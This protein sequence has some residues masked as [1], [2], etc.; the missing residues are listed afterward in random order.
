MRTYS[1]KKVQVLV[2]NQIITGF[3]EDTL[4]EIEKADD[5]FEKAIGA[6]GEVARTQ[7][8]DDSGTI[9]I[10]LMQ[11]SA[12]NDVLQNL[13]DID[14]LSGNDPFPV[15]V[16]DGSGRA[17]YSAQEAWIKKIPNSPFKKRA[18]S[19]VWTIE[20]GVVAHKLGGN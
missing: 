5:D 6:D 16:K 12:S 14:R 1:P 7:S 8:A 3:S 19:R 10:S 17:L 2:G 20:S 15:M 13:R 4:V 9:T 11:T 18:D